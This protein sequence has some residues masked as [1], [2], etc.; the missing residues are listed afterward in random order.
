VRASDVCHSKR[1]GPAFAQLT[2]AQDVK[3]KTIMRA[4]LRALSSRDP[5]RGKKSKRSGI[6]QPRRKE[7][8]ETRLISLHREDG[9]ASRLGCG[10]AHDDWIKKKSCKLSKDELLHS[11]LIAERNRERKER[12][13]K[14]HT[15]YRPVGP[16]PA[17]WR[18][19]ACVRERSSV[20]ARVQQRR[21]AKQGGAPREPK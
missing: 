17:G 10:E 15:V 12:G 5:E 11:A 20:S 9:G 2:I 6:E 19:S 1:K 13:M 14:A 21:E 3:M 16:V 7:G 4:R 8:S 18:C